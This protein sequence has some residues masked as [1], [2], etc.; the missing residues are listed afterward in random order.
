MKEKFL[1]RNSFAIDNIPNSLLYSL[2][3][4]EFHRSKIPFGGEQREKR[5]RVNL[6]INGILMNENRKFSPDQHPT[7]KAANSHIVATRYVTVWTTASRF[8][9]TITK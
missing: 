7:I 8:L 6:H 4:F 2:N 9:V 3:A 5:A 1:Y